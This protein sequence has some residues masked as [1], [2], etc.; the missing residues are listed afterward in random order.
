[1]KAAATSVLVGTRAVSKDGDG[2]SDFQR[3]ESRQDRIVEEQ[4]MIERKVSLLDRKVDELAQ[5]QNAMIEKLD[6]IANFLSPD[7][8]QQKNE[9]V[10]PA[11]NDKKKRPKTTS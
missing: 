9:A 6:A 4:V 3:V 7:L 11:G 10:E 8:N 2:K 1:M 5:Q